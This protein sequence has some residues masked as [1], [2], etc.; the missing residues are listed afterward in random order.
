MKG[1][2]AAQQFDCLL[3]KF[4]ALEL[5]SPPSSANDLLTR[6]LTVQPGFNHSHAPIR[7]S[8]NT[9]SVGGSALSILA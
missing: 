4:S 7:K 9:C 3:L 8:F 6:A 2:S 1:D 5:S